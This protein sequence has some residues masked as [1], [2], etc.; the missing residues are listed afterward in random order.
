MAAAA[1]PPRVVVP[2]AVVN[3]ELRAEYV[4]VARLLDVPVPEEAKTAQTALMKLREHL[5]TSAHQKGH[6]PQSM[7]DSIG[8]LVRLGNKGTLK[9]R[10]KRIVQNRQKAELA[11]VTA[12]SSVQEALHLLECVK[13]EQV[14]AQLDERILSA[15]IE[16]DADVSVAES[17]WACFARV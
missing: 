6:V 9:N 7:S 8:K 17:K 16:D 13:V 3:P 2:P 4:K 11:L 10:R 5:V 14:I 1:A 12:L 15:D